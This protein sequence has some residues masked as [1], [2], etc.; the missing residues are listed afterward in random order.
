MNKKSIFIVFSIII[1]SIC[2]FRYNYINKDVPNKYNIDRYY[3]GED[4]E[5]DDMVIKVTSFEEVEYDNEFYKDDVVQLILG[6]NIRNISDNSIVPG[7]IIESKLNYG[8][9]YV[10]YAEPT[11]EVNKLSKLMPEEEASVTLTYTFY[12]D[13]I[14]KSKEKQE[15]LLY[16]K[17]SLYEDDILKKIGKKE[18]YAKT[19]VLGGNDE[20]Q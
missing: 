6:I 17:T 16:I 10:D 3:I 14:N 11:G 5:L 12:K 1:L 19:I 9:D 7:P 2:V 8:V 4:V 13:S 15:F 20:R 18:L